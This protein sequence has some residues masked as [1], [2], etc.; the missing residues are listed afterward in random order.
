MAELQKQS[1]VTVTL[2]DLEKKEIAQQ[3]AQSISEGNVAVNSSDADK[4]DIASQIAT[5]W[6]QN[7]VSV[8]ISDQDKADIVQEV[9][10]E[11]YAKSQQTRTLERVGNLD[12]IT[13]IPAVRNDKDIVAVPLG[14]LTVA[15]P[16]EIQSEEDIA[17]LE[18]QGKLVETQIYFTKEE[19][20]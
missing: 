5:E 17:I 16:Q 6:A 10:A 15:I 19:D 14:L 20:E 12:G 4:S 8:N 18:A 3:V 7:G 11:L 1:I 13:T 9:L 2:T